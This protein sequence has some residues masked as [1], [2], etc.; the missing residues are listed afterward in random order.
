MIRPQNLVAGIWQ[1]VSGTAVF[2]TVNPRTNTPLPTLFQEASSAQID[3]AVQKAAAVFD[4]YSTSTFHQRSAFLKAIQQELEEIK[5]EL[6]KQYQEESALPEGRAQGEFDRTQGQI[7]SFAELL[8]QGTY[9][10]P[11]ISTQGPDLRKMLHPIGPVAVFG[12]SNF[13][14]AFSTAGGDTISALA[15]GCPVI[16]KAHP[17]HA[18]TSALVAEAIHKALITCELP[19]AVFSHLG[20]VSHDVGATL[21]SHPLLKGVG[22]TGSFRGGKAL[23]DLA[24]QRAEPIP[25]FAEMGSV[26]PI[27]ILENRVLKDESLAP[28]LGQSICLGTGQFCTN[29]GLVLFCDPSGKSTLFNRVLQELQKSAL[30]PMVHDSIE[31]NYADK[32]KELQRNQGVRLARVDQ[33]SAVLGFVEA[34]VVLEQPELVEEVFG[35]F[36]LFVRCKSM[37]EM[38]AAAAALPGQLTATVLFDKEE[39]TQATPLMNILKSKVGRLLFEG[40]PTGVAVTQ[41]MQHGGPYPASTDGRYTSVGTDAIYRWLRPV[42]YQDCPNAL[43]PEPLQNENPLS[44]MR[45]VNGK[46]TNTKL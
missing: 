35:P 44:L 5:E 22:F 20:G 37:E 16:V 2:Q 42:A 43:L 26:N 17:Y 14:L 9:V 18:G 15:A 13:P 1:E 25:V 33:N 4:V 8:D 30:P 23:Y 29:P 45:I 3:E 11:I 39:M 24:Q 46:Q 7:Q 36:S 19:L 41:A 40:V 38:Q 12:A 28:T 34:A 27:F 31:K 21:V 6:L 32:L 10:Q